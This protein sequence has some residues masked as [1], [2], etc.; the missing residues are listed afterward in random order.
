VVYGDGEQTRDFNFVGNAVEAN[1]R[2]A[3]CQ[4]SAFGMSFNIACGARI[5]LLELIE[6]IN[7]IFGKSVAP[8][9]EE[10]R[11]G[12]VKHSLADITAAEKHLQWRP[13]TTLDEGLRIT[14][15]WFSR[16]TPRAE[17]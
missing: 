1:L 13:A 11:P 7:R 12:D 6:R 10:S 4:S 5:S 15:D 9:H 17:R 2:A 16:T 14:A 3:V 8:V